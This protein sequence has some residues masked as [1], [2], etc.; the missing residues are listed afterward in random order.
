MAVLM[1]FTKNALENANKK[2]KKTKLH[3]W[4]HYHEKIHGNMVKTPFIRPL[5]V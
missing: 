3:C 4:L 1:N 5:T 2:K